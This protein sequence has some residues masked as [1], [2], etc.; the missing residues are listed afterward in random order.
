ML[1]GPKSRRGFTLVELLI[2]I[3]IL[4]MLI[5]LLVPSLNLGKQLAIRMTCRSNLHQLMVGWAA[6][7]G[8]NE[9]WLPGPKGIVDADAPDCPACPGAIDHPGAAYW[10]WRGTIPTET[11]L[12][13]K[14]GYVT[15]PKVWLCGNAE[16]VSPGQW[17]ENSL[18]SPWTYHYTINARTYG[19]DEEGDYRYDHAE[20]RQQKLTFFNNPG[21]TIGMGE[22]NTGMLPRGSGEGYC[23]EV[24]ND[25]DFVEPDQAEPRHVGA[26][27]VGYLDGHAGQV[28]PYTKIYEAE[29]CP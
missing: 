11:G 9:L 7:A 5:A 8:E 2:V 25:T 6:Y 21:Q 18:T 14:G 10:G 16:L 26:S 23:D 28:P 24:L 1:Y 20:N 3:A 17:Y 27:Q 22:E 29:Y 12:L 4:A 15:N 13:H 19:L